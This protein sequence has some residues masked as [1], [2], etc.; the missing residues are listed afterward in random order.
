MIVSHRSIMCC[1]NWYNTTARRKKNS[2]TFYN[3]N[4]ASLHKMQTK[5]RCGATTRLKSQQV[6]CVI[7]LWAFYF[8]PFFLSICVCFFFTQC[9][10]LTPSYYILTLELSVRWRCGV[11]LSQF[12]TTEKDHTVSRQPI[13]VGK[14]EDSCKRWSMTTRSCN[15][16]KNIDIN[17]SKIKPST[18]SAVVRARART[19]SQK[20]IPWICLPRHH[21]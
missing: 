18:S 5:K 17:S 16:N 13:V 6:K 8:P 2:Q 14:G 3:N 21:P 20:Q 4:N 9:A 11:L 15:S 1:I 12:S 7:I 10:G 19:I